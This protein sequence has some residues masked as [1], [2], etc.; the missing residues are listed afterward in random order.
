MDNRAFARL[1]HRQRIVEL[2]VDGSVA[3]IHRIALA[4]GMDPRW[5]RRH[6]A[7][8]KAEGWL[9]IDRWRDPQATLCAHATYIRPFY[10]LGAEPDAPRPPALTY[11]EKSRQRRKVLR[12]DRIEWAFGLARRRALNR[13]PARDPLVAAVFGGA[14]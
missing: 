12:K 11:A 7:D 5:A 8:C 4:L 14:P 9:R 10:A 2:L 6:V 13:Q 1:Q 3:D